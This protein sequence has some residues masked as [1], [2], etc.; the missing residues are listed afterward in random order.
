MISTVITSKIWWIDNNN[1]RKYI[2]SSK[3]EMVSASFCCMW[4]DL[5]TFHLYTMSHVQYYSEITM[6]FTSLSF[7]SHWTKTRTA[8]AELNWTEQK[9]KEDPNRVMWSFQSI[10]CK[11]LCLANNRN[12]SLHY[13]SMFC[14]DWFSIVLL[15]DDKLHLNNGLENW[16]EIQTEFCVNSLYLTTLKTSRLIISV[17]FL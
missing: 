5:S 14:L 9:R 12:P 2:I 8:P 6:I 7:H 1:W 4:V 17:Y 16:N 3:H 13:D 15:L 11:N 10:T